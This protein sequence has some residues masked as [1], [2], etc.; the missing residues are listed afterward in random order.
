MEGKPLGFV[1][2]LMHDMEGIPFNIHCNRDYRFVTN[3]M[4]THRILNEVPDHSTYW[5]KYG[6]W[7]MSSTPSISPVTIASSI[8]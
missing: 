1:K 5:K 4:S 2:T 8:G 3:L 6:E 7:V